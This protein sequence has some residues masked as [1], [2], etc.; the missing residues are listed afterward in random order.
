MIII[1]DLVEVNILNME[2]KNWILI[3][4]SNI[5]LSTTIES[6]DARIFLSIHISFYDDDGAKNK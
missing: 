3:A 2:F 5:L 4:M 6:I 1:V